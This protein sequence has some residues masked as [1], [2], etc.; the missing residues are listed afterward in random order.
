M[1][2]SGWE[3][4]A[5]IDYNGQ[6]Y[7]IDRGRSGFQPHKIKELPTCAAQKVSCNTSTTLVLLEDGTVVI[8][9]SE[10]QS[11]GECLPDYS[12]VVDVAAAERYSFLLTKGTT[13]QLGAGERK[14]ERE[15]RRSPRT[16]P[17]A[18]PD[19]EWFHFP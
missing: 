14:R 3:H 19:R 1:V 13:T 2:S 10:S 4:S 6:L 5:A 16:W 12:S 8:Y 15:S 11:S 7:W 17:A 18:L 9:R